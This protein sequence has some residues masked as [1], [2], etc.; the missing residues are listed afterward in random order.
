MRRD[1][2]LDIST[3]ISGVDL[4][5]VSMFLSRKSEQCSP[6]PVWSEEAGRGKGLVSSLN[7]NE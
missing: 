6:V 3:P 4:S 5:D 2:I 7:E 1:F